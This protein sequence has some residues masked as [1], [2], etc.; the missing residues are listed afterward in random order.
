MDP[1]DPFNSAGAWM[2]QYSALRAGRQSDNASEQ[3]SFER[4][5]EQL[6]LDSPDESSTDSSSTHQ[7][8][9]EDSREI[10]RANIGGS[11]RM[12][13]HSRLGD[14][15]FRRTRH[16]VDIPRTHLGDSTEVLPQS[17]LRDDL[18]SSARYGLPMA[19]PAIE[20]SSKSRGLW[21][22]IKS[23]VTKAFGGSS[24][25][26]SSGSAARQEFVSRTFRA[27]HAKQPG[28]TR[29]VPDDDEALFEEFKSR[30]T[31]A[32]TEG[33]IRNAIADLRHLS[34]RLSENGRPSIADRIGNPALA[35]ELDQD[36][37]TYAKNRSR[38]IKAALKKLRDVGAGKALSADIRRL[39]PYPVDATLVDMWAAAE[40][41]TQR[42][43]PES[44]DRQARRL[45]RLSDWLQTRER[46]AM[47]GRLFTAGLTQDV[48]AYRQETKDS[49]INADL[50]RLGRYQQVLDANRAL[51][52]HPPVDAP[53]LFG[54]GAQEPGPPQELPA[55]PATPSSGAW[56]VFREAMR[57]PTPSS[58]TPQPNWS[59]EL[60]ATPAAPSAGAWDLFREPMQGPA[61]SSSGR[62]PSSDI[63]GGLDPL[64]SL[65]PPTPYE[66][67]DDAHSAPAPAFARPPSFAGPSRAS[68]EL[69]EIGHIVGEGWEHLSQPASPVLV[70]V[71]DN[72]NL[73]PNQYG[74]SQFLINGELY[75]AT[76]GAGG[77][78][79]VRLIHHPRARPTN[80]AGPSYQ[81]QADI[82]PLIRGVWQHRER[83]L[84]DYLIPDLE[85][86]RLIPSAG[87]PT[88]FYIRTVPYRAELQETNRGPRVRLYPQR[89]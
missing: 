17:N 52:L 40:K 4:Q 74:P 61:A 42:I 36:A 80:E 22:R 7:N 67:R 28:R 11:M 23:G 58:S 12:P 68:Q 83:W 34:G 86:E 33:T 43:E 89:G 45:Y 35:D 79:D 32:L 14:N 53:P 39:N 72:I 59:L 56:G 54:E 57:E 6:Q 62:R 37:E 49:K 13:P 5:I 9:A 29:G 44:V 82:G 24:S 76:L 60:P 2:Q 48:E 38:R 75:S 15:S 84:P 3:G 88:S 69:Q 1:I 77:R 87:R 46:E 71:L 70:D 10:R 81:P 73:L 27:D 25:G 85:G 8:P 51:G 20:K 64:V 47:A 26:G 16:S 63:Y 31:G 18:F 65:D 19:Q 30:A 41:V 21:S 66:L 78:R 50:L 55:T